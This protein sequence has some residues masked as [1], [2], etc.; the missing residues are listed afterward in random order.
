MKKSLVH[1]LI[2]VVF[3]APS[4]VW[5]N[6]W[7][8]DVNHSSIRFGV[9]HIFSTVSGYFPDFKGKIVFDPDALDQSAFDF[10]VK[11]KSI[12]TANTKRDTHLRSDDFFSADTFPN[13]KFRSSKIVHQGGSLYVVTGTMTLK[14]TSRSMDIPF[15]FHGVLPSPF[16][17]KEEVAGFD[18]E[19][20][21]NRLDFGVGSGKFSKMGVVDEMVRVVISIEAL[22]EI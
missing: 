18:T 9:K 3:F 22:G 11:V 14:E 5:G 1:L 15:T 20:T 6:E 2:L 16:N 17:K 4:L 13:M 12:N 21:I 8:I 10:T 7:K 19:F